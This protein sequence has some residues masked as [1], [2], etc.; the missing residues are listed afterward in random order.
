MEIK[1]WPI[2]K[3]K[4]V[5][6]SYEVAQ[7]LKEKGFDKDCKYHFKV[8]TTEPGKHTNTPTF[9]VKHPFGANHN[10]MPTRVSAPV[11]SQAIDWVY[12]KT[13]NIIMYNPK[14]TLDFLLTEFE[15]ALK[16]I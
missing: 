14:F 5:W 6:V 11:W 1:D 9:E 16:R 15:T 4:Q 13:G 2:V 7:L 12:E 10:L 8:S 3:N